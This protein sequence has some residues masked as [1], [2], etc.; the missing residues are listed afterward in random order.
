MLASPH[1][2]GLE[3]VAADQGFRETEQPVLRAPLADYLLP[4]I[5]SARA[6]TGLA[7]FIGTLTL[8]AVGWLVGRLAARGRRRG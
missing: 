3:R 4:G 1:P 7:G 8:L 5:R 2:D 6:A